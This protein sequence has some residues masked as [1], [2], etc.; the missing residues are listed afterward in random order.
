MSHLL[1]IK[2]LNFIYFVYLFKRFI[3]KTTF[4][5]FT[6][7]NSESF[8]LIKRLSLTQNF[9]YFFILSYTLLLKNFI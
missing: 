1:L 2:K 8:F 3:T 6:V 9:N 4:K 5:I 7:Y